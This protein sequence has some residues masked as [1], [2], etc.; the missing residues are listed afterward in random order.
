MDDTDP[1]VIGELIRQTKEFI[2][3]QE[4]LEI[5]HAYFGDDLKIRSMF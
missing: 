4:Y 3:T 1:Y 2:K 5:I